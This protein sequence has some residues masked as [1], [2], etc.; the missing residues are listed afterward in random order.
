MGIVT[1]KELLTFCNLTNLK[2][3]YAK[4]KYFDTDK[5]EE[6]NH[7]IYSL[8]DEEIKSF[9]SDVKK[10][11]FQLKENQFA[12]DKILMILKEEKKSGNKK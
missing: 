8:L 3:E 5:K 11:Y 9:N 1:D 6:V 12:K 10:T 2:M 4:L 7:T